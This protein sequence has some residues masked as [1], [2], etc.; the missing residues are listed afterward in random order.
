MVLELARRRHEV[1]ALGREDLDVTDLPAVRRCFTA[2][3]PDVVVNCAAYTNADDAEREREAALATNALGAR[4]VAISCREART[5]LLHFSTDYV[6]DGE[7]SEPYTIWDS[8]AP[9]NIYGVSKMWGENF[10]RS[11][12][13]EHYVVRASWLFA[14]HG[15]NFV[16]TMLRL[17]GASGPNRSPGQP[18]ASTVSTG[19][20]VVPV[21]TDQC[22]SPTYAVDLAKA[23]ADLLET[24]C[25]GT[26]HV[27]NHGTVTRYEFARAIFEMAGLAVDVRP[28]RSEAFPGTAR[29]PRNSALDPFPL[30]ET[31]G[32]LLPP[33]Q[34]ALKRYLG[35]RDPGT[36]ADRPTKPVGH[37]AGGLWPREQ[38]ELAT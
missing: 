13:D 5:V 1:I 24:G 26:Y 33:W 15:R 12:L 34:D 32:Y 20:P 4:N 10:V 6:F 29:R 3:R 8:P 23:C 35:H 14:S 16:E 38:E 7:K 9:L 36:Q 2:W 30:H 31:I 21:V 22:G 11:L 28:A 18:C 37:A 17:G 19:L 27:T 25:F